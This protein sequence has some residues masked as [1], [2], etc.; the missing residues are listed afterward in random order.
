MRFNNGQVQISQLHVNIW[1]LHTH[2]ME[3]QVRTLVNS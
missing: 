2:V 1:Q 3:S